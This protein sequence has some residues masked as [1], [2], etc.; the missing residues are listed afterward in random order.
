MPHQDKLPT[1][2]YSLI[3]MQQERLLIVYKELYHINSILNFF[4]GGNTTEEDPR[5]NNIQ[6]IIDDINI[7]RGKV[8]CLNNETLE[9][10]KSQD[11]ISSNRIVFLTTFNYVKI[12]I[13]DMLKVV[14]TIYNK[15]RQMFNESLN[16]YIPYPSLGRRYSNHSLMVYLEYIFRDM[17]TQLSKPHNKTDNT[18]KN[19][20]LDWDYKTD[21]NYRKFY[22][23]DIH[24][25]QIGDYNYYI[26]LPYSYY[27]LP[28]LLP[29]ITYNIINIILKNKQ[30]S[31]FNELKSKVQIELKRDVVDKSILVNNVYDLFGHKK[32]IEDLV[33]DIFSDTVAFYLHKEAYIYSLA[34]QA[35]GEGLARDFFEQNSDKNSFSIRPHTWNFSIQKDHIILR[36]WLLIKLS[37]EESKKKESKKKELI[38]TI[39]GFLRSLI[40][41]EQNDDIENKEKERRNYE[42]SFEYIYQNNY[43]NFYESYKNTRIYLKILYEFFAQ[44][45]YHYYLKEYIN[46][47]ERKNTNSSNNNENNS[48]WKYQD[49][50][51][52]CWKERFKT[53]EDSSGEETRHPNCFRYKLHEKLLKEAKREPQDTYYSLRLF[54]IR[55]VFEQDQDLNEALKTLQKSSLLTN[56]ENTNYP[57]KNFYSYGIYDFINIKKVRDVNSIQK[58]FKVYQEA[59]IQNQSDKINFFETRHIL[60]RVDK[61]GRESKINTI[62]LNNQAGAI[63]QIE[64]EKNMQNPNGYENLAQSIDHL[65]T[66]LKDHTCNNYMIF[67]S[68]GPKDLIVFV[69]NKSI[70]NI[71]KLSTKLCQANYIRRTFT[72]IFSS[73]SNSL[74]VERYITKRSI[75]ICSYLRVK[76]SSKL[77]KNSVDGTIY[78]ITGVMDKK[79]MWNSGTNLKTVNQFYKKNAQNLTDFH[80]KFEIKDT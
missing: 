78:S 73:N 77:N 68:L 11:S 7:I 14:D 37:E 57:Y 41:L 52:R 30:N 69:F 44:K 74:K 36:L 24:K 53:L 61:D 34:H 5:K 80:T 19:I 3:A 66:L 58:Q 28:Y 8:E 38:N 48:F 27:E 50:F 4:L 45:K 59:F 79:I 75:T 42:D 26:D 32:Y 6:H 51:N 25:E 35:L 9:P 10:L 49:Y 22:S 39:K 12:E 64:L 33:D 43:P 15:M 18:T 16:Q 56:Q 47:Y 2:T 63:F 46:T 17:L 54:K 20:I 1:F 71:H 65:E 60:L 72:S 40:D 31:Q 62:E 67:K 70:E 76:N 21:F 29:S 13:E 55:K 23:S